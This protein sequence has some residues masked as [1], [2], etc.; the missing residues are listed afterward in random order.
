MCTHCTHLEELLVGRAAP[1]ESSIHQ[2][3]VQ[4]RSC[5]PVHLRRASAAP[6]GELTPSS[7]KESDLHKHNT[8]P[9]M[10]ENNKRGGGEGKEHTCFDHTPDCAT[11]VHPRRSAEISCW[12]LASRRCPGSSSMRCRRVSIRAVSSS[13]RKKNKKKKKKGH[14]SMNDLSTKGTIKE[15]GR[16]T[17][18]HVL[19][20]QTTQVLTSHQKTSPADGAAANSSSEGGPDRWPAGAG[21]HPRRRGR[22]EGSCLPPVLVPPPWL[23]VGHCYALKLGAQCSAARAPAGHTSGHASDGAAD[24]AARARASPPSEPP[25]SEATEE[26]PPL[27]VCPLSFFFPFFQLDGRQRERER[28]RGREQ[29]RKKE[30]KKPCVM[31]RSRRVRR[32]TPEDHR[33]LC[34][35]T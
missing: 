3:G 23:P 10:R 21:W 35:H 24:L 20:S 14:Q 11:S 32:G 16:H 17:H 31:S 1:E 19:C 29:E 5:L 22:S 2:H 15:G 28:E 27:R 4:V 18:W 13:E 12:G 7:K 33:P 8:H 30:R 25:C 9:P 34:L 26:G 6:G